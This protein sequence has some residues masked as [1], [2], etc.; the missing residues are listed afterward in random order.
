MQIIQTLR[1]APMAPFPATIEQPVRE[2][3]QIALDPVRN[4]ITSMM[5]IA[6][7]EEMPGTHPWVIQTR[8]SLNW[9]TVHPQAGYSWVFP[10]HSTSN[11]TEDIPRIFEGT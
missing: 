8:T 6:K 4:A 3:V 10:R 5:L 2:R 7:E 9:R 1:R 11:R